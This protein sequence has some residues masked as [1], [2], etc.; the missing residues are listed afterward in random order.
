MAYK[1]E[2]WKTGVI[3]QVYPRSFQDSNGDGIG[4]LPGIMQRLD[5]LQWLGV[6]AIWVS[7]CFPSPMVDFGYD[8]SDHTD[9]DPIFGTLADMDALIEAVHARG[10]KIILDYVPAHTSDQHPWFIESRASRDNPKRDW[11]V[12]RDPAPDGGPPNNWLCRFDGETVWEWDEKT[13]QYYMHYFFKAQ[14]DLNWHNPELRAT[15]LNI[16]RFWFDRG[17]DGLRVDAC[18]RAIKDPLFRDNPPNHDWHDGMDPS[19]KMIEKYTKNLPAVHQFNRWVRAVADEYDERML[20]GEL[21]LST[22]QV[23]THYGQNDEFHLPLNSGIFSTPWYAEA[24]HGL[25]DHYESSLPEGA[26]PNWVIGNHDKHRFATHVGKAQARV[27]MMLLLTLRGTPTLYYGD[28]IGMADVEI[29]LDEIQDPWEKSAPNLGLGRDPERTP[30]QWDSSPNASFCQAEV[31]PW[32]RLSD[33]YKQVNV[34]SSRDKPYSMLSLTQAIIQLRR[35]TAA[36]SIGDYYSLYAPEGIFAYRRLQDDEHIIIALNFTPYPK[37]WILPVEMRGVSTILLSTL[38][39]R[40]GEKL[41]E[42]LDLRG[43][44]GVI[45]GRCS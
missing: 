34:A 24:M 18:Y 4:D 13:G 29:P 44:E 17:I 21:Y 35:A 39:D 9:I 23:V 32:M 10:I 12:W 26:W 25:V 14:P 41:G 40:Q 1:N 38:L 42:S 16:L 15:M 28:E 33:D 20:I 45:L 36:L 22:E 6:D 5:Y 7:P 3:Y 30:M 43:D 37:T 2:W 19:L 11:Y 31:S 27:G 8:I